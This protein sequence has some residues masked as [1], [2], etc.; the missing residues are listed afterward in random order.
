MTAGES[1]G[2]TTCLSSSA[3][4]LK[5]RLRST[6]SHKKRKTGLPLL[7]IL[8]FL[9]GMIVGRIAYSTERGT[10]AELTHEEVGKLVWANSGPGEEKRETITKLDNL[11]EYLSRLQ[12][13]KISYDYQERDSELRLYVKEED[14][15]TYYISDQYLDVYN[16]NGFLEGFY[17]VKN[18]VDWEYIN[19]L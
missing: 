4:T 14:G 8:L 3:E 6:V 7:F 9:S 2:Y 18:P 17:H 16:K 1:G 5:Y 11:S 19:T 10:I 15:R 12:V 13:E